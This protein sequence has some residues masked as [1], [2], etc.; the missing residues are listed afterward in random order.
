MPV[1]D[2]QKRANAKHDKNHFEY[3]TLKLKRSDRLPEL[4]AIAIAIA[5]GC[6]KSKNAYMIDAIKSRLEA[7][8][9][10]IEDLPPIEHTSD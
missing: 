3:Q 1:S 7:D 9:I 2:A 6:A 10:K 4:I 8:G 5:R